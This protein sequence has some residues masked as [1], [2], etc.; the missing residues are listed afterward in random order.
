MA[1]IAEPMPAP[2]SEP[3]SILTGGLQVR[4]LVIAHAWVAIAAFAFRNLSEMLEIVG[5]S[6]HHLGP[7]VEDVSRLARRISDAVPGSP[8]AIDQDGIDPFA[9]KLGRDHRS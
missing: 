5:P 7:H 4:K 9:R 3:S 2:R 6:A 8:A 1:T